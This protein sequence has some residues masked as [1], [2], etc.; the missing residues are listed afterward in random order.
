MAIR[1]VVGGV[2]DRIPVKTV[3]LSVFDKTG[4]ET[5]VPGLVEA[6]PGVRLLSTGGTYKKLK[7]L[8]VPNLSEVAE[9]T[10]SPEMEGGLVKTLHPMI[11]GGILGERNNPAHQKYLEGGNGRFIDLVVVNLYPFEKVIAQQDVTFEAARGNIDIGGPTMIRGA[12]K[13][14]LSCAPIIDPQDYEAILGH[15]RTNN[16][17]TTLEYRLSLVPKAF[18]HTAEYDK[19]IAAFTA[20][21]ISRHGTA[22][23][24][25]YELKG[26]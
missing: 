5:F 3:L 25:N 22:V 18:A 4:L 12:A 7:E 21:Q 9:Y 6:A 23:L 8:G 16:G 15:I 2:T 11:H 26:E 17:C 13:N 24:G 10:G 1:G 19:A 14:A 20:E